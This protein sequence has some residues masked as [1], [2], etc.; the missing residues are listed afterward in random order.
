MHRLSYCIAGWDCFRASPQ[1]SDY[2]LSDQQSY[3]RHSTWVLSQQV[4]LYEASKA[5]QATHALHCWLPST[6]VQKV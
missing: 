2:E 3:H 1:G 6:A 4:Q 5:K